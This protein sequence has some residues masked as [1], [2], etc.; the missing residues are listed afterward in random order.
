MYCSLFRIILKQQ[1]CNYRKI[2]VQSSV[3]SNTKDLLK[4]KNRMEKTRPKGPEL[5]GKLPCCMPE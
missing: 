5:A 4:K 2:R 3:K 1:L